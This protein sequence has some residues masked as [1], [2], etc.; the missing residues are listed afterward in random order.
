MGGYLISR[1]SKARKLAKTGRN[2]IFGSMAP[3]LHTSAMKTAFD[4]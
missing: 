2:I 1:P 3:G 4:V